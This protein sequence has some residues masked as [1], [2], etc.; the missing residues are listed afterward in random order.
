MSRNW[1]RSLA[2]GSL[3]NSNRL[4]RGS[5][6]SSRGSKLCGFRLD[7]AFRNEQ[8]AALSHAGAVN[9]E[10]GRASSLICRKLLRDSRVVFTGLPIRAKPNPLFGR[11][12]NSSV[13]RRDV[14]ICAPDQCESHS[15]TTSKQHTSHL[16]ARSRG[17]TRCEMFALTLAPLTYAAAPPVRTA[18]EVGCSGP[19]GVRLSKIVILRLPTPAF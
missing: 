8:I 13:Q 2:R 14:R 9:V 6:A 16:K 7:L 17:H 15:S 3:L 19:P 5:A 12:G 18:S 11:S 10:H 4:P 1:P